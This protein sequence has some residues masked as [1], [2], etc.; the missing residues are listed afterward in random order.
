VDGPTACGEMVRDVCL[1]AWNF[2][3]TMSTV[4]TRGIEKD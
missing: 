1:F 4:L 2:S 3:L